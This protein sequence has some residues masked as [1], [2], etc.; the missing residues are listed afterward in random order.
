MSSALPSPALSP[1]PPPRLPHPCGRQSAPAPLFPCMPSGARGAGRGCPQHFSQTPS[2]RDFER[3]GREEAG[4]L[5]ERLKL[6]SP[7]AGWPSCEDWGPGP[8]VM[9]EVEDR[10]FGS[11]WALGTSPLRHV[12][13]ATGMH[14]FA[15]TPYLDPH[16]GQDSSH[17]AVAGA[18]PTTVPSPTP[19]LR[20]PLNGPVSQV[21]LLLLAPCAAPPGWPAGASSALAP[22]SLWPAQGGRQGVC[23]RSCPEHLAAVLLPP[24]PKMGKL[25]LGESQRLAKGHLA[26]RREIR[27]GVPSR[28]W[29]PTLVSEVE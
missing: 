4:A 1:H 11:L 28:P 5:P 7:K 21:T 2:R 3:G 27:T 19:G 29:S 15:P 26:G 20:A 18:G 6:R 17:P 12:E 23:Y 16:S 8:K 13:G 9:T 10:T 14:A 25:G 24:V 22:S